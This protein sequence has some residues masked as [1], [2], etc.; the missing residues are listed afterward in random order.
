VTAA[1]GRRVAYW[2]AWK[3]GPRLP[4]KPGEPEFLAAYAAAVAAR[5]AAHAAARHPGRPR[6][7]LPGG[8]RIHPLG[9]RHPRGWARWLDRIGLDRAE[10]DTDIG[11]LPI[12]A[13]DDRRVRKE[14]LA[15]R[16]HG[17]DRPR[18]ADYAMQVL[19]RRNWPSASTAASCRSTPQA[20]VAQ[21]YDPDGRGD[22]VWT[23]AEEARFVAAARLA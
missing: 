4:G 17:P 7:P 10:H 14:L 9:R 1:D 13:L 6:R 12:G 15:W 19:S 2:Y 11:G 3:G 20:G 8:P 21:L 18:A 5:K 16:D 23:P 22:Q